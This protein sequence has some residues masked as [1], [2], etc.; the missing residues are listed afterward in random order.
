M[1]LA[2]VVAAA[3]SSDWNINRNASEIG[4]SGTHAGRAFDGEFGQ[5]TARIRFNPDNLGNSRIV[6]V[7]DTGTATTGD[8]VQETTLKNAE[9]FDSANHRFATFSSNNIRSRGG[10][11][12]T[13][14][15]TLEIRGKKA[16]VTLP[17]TVTINGNNARANG[18]K[19]DPRAQWVSRNINLN[20]Q[21]AAT[22]G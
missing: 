15:G 5:W 12:Y 21:V 18:T 3:Q 17:F 6:V 19:S 1:V 13:A 11:R 14:D 9:W 2:P 20:F 8:R 10:N 16:P 22:R 7:V 4:F